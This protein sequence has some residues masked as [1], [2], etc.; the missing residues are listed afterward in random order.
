MCVYL[1]MLLYYNVKIH[2]TAKVLIQFPLTSLALALLT[3]RRLK[4]NIPTMFCNNI[5]ALS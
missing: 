3:Q 1:N 4:E 2:N 5:L